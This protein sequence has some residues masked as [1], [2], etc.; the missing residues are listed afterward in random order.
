MP[1]LR[2]SECSRMILLISQEC[3]L[4]LRGAGQIHRDTTHRINPRTV[5]RD[6]C[7]DRRRDPDNI[8]TLT[9]A[10]PAPNVAL[11]RRGAPRFPGGI[12]FWFS[13]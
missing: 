5:Y 9:K 10:S 1:R 11:T 3:Q 6:Y 4:P 12:A 13:L 7:L 2:R 8:E